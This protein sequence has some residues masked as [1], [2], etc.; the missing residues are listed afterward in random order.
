MT[1][2][3]SRRQFTRTSAAAI[4]AAALGIRP[5]AAAQQL[6]LGTYGGDTQR[7]IENLILKPNLEP[8]GIVTSIEATSD[9]PRRLKLMAER[10]LPRGTFDVVHCHAPMLYELYEQGLLEKLDMSRL[11][12]FDSLV[13]VLKKE[14]AVPHIMTSR[15][16]L[17]NPKRISPAPTAFADFGNPKYAG[18]IGFIDMH[19]AMAIS[20]ASL[21]NGG[22]M[23]NY[24][25]GKAK[26]ME[27]KKAGV[28]VYPSNEAFGQALQTEECWMGVMIQS[29]GIMWKNAG[30]PVEIAYAKEGIAVDWWGFGIPKNARNKDAAYAFLNAALSDKAQTGWAQNMWSAP[31]TTTGMASLEPSV[32]S[33]IDLPAGVKDKVIGIDAAYLAKNDAQLKDW[34]DRVFKA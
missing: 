25:P 21:A 23:S 34:W 32:K 5:A 28:R 33:L 30:V 20:S 14:Y 27:L 19:Y 31:S 17:Y 11:P 9:G 8:K 29:R 12:F 4:G 22:S 13:P 10:R 1:G 3:V 16:I 26:L 15:V 7:Y 24:E 18:K 6:V 2:S